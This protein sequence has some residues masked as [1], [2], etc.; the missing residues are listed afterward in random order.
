MNNEQDP[1]FHMLL[2]DENEYGYGV[3][4]DP[5]LVFA[6]FQP[7]VEAAKTITL[8]DHWRHDRVYIVPVTPVVGASADVDIASFNMLTRYPYVEHGELWVWKE[9]K[10]VK[11]SA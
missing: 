6:F 4:F 2:W 11:A 5:P 7:A 10:H 1:A 9:G 8:G 3:S